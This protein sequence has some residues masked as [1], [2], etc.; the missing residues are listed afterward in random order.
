MLGSSK[1]MRIFFGIPVPEEK[2]LEYQKLLLREHPEIKHQVRWTRAGNH[3][4]TVRF[5]GNVPEQ[6]IPLFEEPIKTS[7]E[8]IH[9]FKV[10]LRHIAPFPSQHGKMGAVLIQPSNELQALYQAV[11]LVVN[12]LGFPSEERAYLPHITLYRQ[13][14]KQSITFENIQLGHE[15]IEIKTLYLYQSINIEN[16]TLYVPLYKF[17]LNN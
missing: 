12:Q 2:A 5:L 3:H 4:I 13:P 10:Q 1:H 17:P 14:N 9:C 15:S 16:G 6:K 7:I 11:D 8:A